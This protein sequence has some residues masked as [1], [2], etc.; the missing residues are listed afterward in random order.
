MREIESK[1]DMREYFKESFLKGQSLEETY[2]ILVHQGY[3]RGLINESYNE[4]LKEARARKEQIAKRDAPKPIIEI[5]EPE[6][7]KKE[8]FFKRIFKRD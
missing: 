2:S 8:N 1:K 6:V 7:Q 3:S 5:I 4:F